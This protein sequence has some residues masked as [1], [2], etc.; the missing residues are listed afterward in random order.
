M[1]AL[2][3]FGGRFT[4]N[5]WEDFFLS[6]GAIDFRDAWL[7]AVAPS[8]ELA[9]LSPRLSL[10]AEAQVGR[11]IGDQR[12]WEVNALVAARYRLSGPEA[13]VRA[14]LAFGLGPSWASRKPV[15]ERRVSD[16]GDS[17]RWL[18]YWYMEATAAPRAWGPWSA[19]I[20]LHHRSGAYG[21]VAEAGGS[22]TPTVGIRRRF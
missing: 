13:P 9:R 17:S 18:V 6:P 11:Y 10:E 21:R 22:N 4:A 2:T 14:S 8:W 19:L 16:N 1:D 15:L 7:V 20:R 12:N 5:H 3:V